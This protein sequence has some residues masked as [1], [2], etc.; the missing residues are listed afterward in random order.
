MGFTGQ[1]PVLTPNF[2]RFSKDAL[3]FNQS[4]ATRPICSPNRSILLTG[5]YA[6]THG[7]YMNGLEA[8]LNPNI[9]MIGSMLKEAGY[10]TSYVGKL[11][12]GGEPEQ[13]GIIPPLHRRGWDHWVHA[14][15]HLPFEQPY[16]IGDATKRAVHDGWAPDYETD[17]TI[18]FIREHR[19][20][21]FAAMLSWGPPHVGWGK[22]F[23]DRWQP[24]KREGGKIP[25]GLGCAA[26]AKYEA[27]YR[28]YDKIPRRA[29][30][31]PVPAGKG[32]LDPT[33]QD[34][35]GYFGAC[36]AL[37]SSFGRLVES[38]RELNLYDNT[39]IVFTSD[40]GEMEGSHG[41]VQKGI[42]FEEAIGV[43]LL[44]RLG[45]Q[46]PARRVDSLCSTVDLAPTIFGLLGVPQHKQFEGQDFSAFARGRASQTTDA[47]FLSFDAAGP[48]A[49]PEMKAARRAWQTIRT[50]RYSY[51]LL[52]SSQARNLPNKDRRVL[53]D[54]VADPYQ[55]QPIFGDKHQS[56]MDDLHGRLVAHLAQ[57]GDDFIKTKFVW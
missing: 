56:L 37:D 54:L 12:T 19:D 31:R 1:D 27:P 6:Q 45:D 24:G 23:E 17:Q 28:P 9:P 13:R 41:R 52:D 11:H 20:Q 15:G 18:A 55:M 2:D 26:P 25:F 51:T 46:L 38:L 4:C 47:T 22:G 34:L 42:Y 33:D 29:N 32:Q 39:L 53:Y 16:F 36:T 10:I 40:H 14:V 21:P 49:T 35:P 57:R 30:V 50:E 7:H 5:L 43:P 44:M 8:P 48:T 3:V